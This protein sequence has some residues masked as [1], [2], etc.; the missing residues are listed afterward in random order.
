MFECDSDHF[1]K[2]LEKIVSIISFNWEGKN[3]PYKLVD[4][5]EL[6]KLIVYWHV[7]TFGILNIAKD[8]YSEIPTLFLFWNLQRHVEK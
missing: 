2:N 7:S 1:E 3:S 4:L 5:F 6:L 8:T